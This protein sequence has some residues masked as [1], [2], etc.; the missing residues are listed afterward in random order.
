MSKLFSFALV[1]VLA[2]GSSL[3]TAAEHPNIV[4]ITSEDHGPE[5]GC[6]G[7]KL[8]ATPNVDALA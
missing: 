5:M 1:W 4:W 3:V 2:F 8:A 7:D 6:Y